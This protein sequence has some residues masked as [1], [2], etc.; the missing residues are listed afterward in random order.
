M[1]YSPEN[2]GENNMAHLLIDTV[3]TD[4]GK[5]Y[6]PFGTHRVRL[7]ADKKS[8]T[9]FRS[10]LR[11]RKKADGKKN[12]SGSGRFRL[13]VL[14]KSAV[15]AAILAEAEKIL[16]TDPKAEIAVISPRRKLRLKLGKL[17]QRHPDARIFC[18][19]KLGKKARRFLSAGNRPSE[20]VSDGLQAGNALVQ[21][22]E[23]NIIAEAA[24]QVRAAATAVLLP[25]PQHPAPAADTSTV[26]AHIV[27]LIRKNRPKKNTALLALLQQQHAAD[28]AALLAG[29][30][31]Q[32]Y[33]K[34]DA[35]ENV[36]YL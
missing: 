24:V 28:A 8:A 36:R 17:Q 11:I 32:G 13:L 6:I 33:L 10:L 31:Q 3:K 9:P 7:F 34:I 23:N 30:Q 18:G 15:R 26:P 16:A 19:G 14:R 35:A 20:N 12:Q 5:K 1:V 29:L 22:T 2:K 4:S 25:P 27:L 21:E